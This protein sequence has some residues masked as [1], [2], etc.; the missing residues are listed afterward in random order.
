MQN[1]LDKLY[2]VNF[3]KVFPLQ[4][5][6]EITYPYTIIK[7]S[8]KS[9]KSYLIF[10]YLKQ[11]K[12]EQY[13]YIDLNDM[14]IDKNTIFY[15]L[16]RFLLQNR[17]I[18]I[19]VLDNI[20]S[21][22]N[23][24]FKHLSILKS[25]IISTSYDISYKNFKTVLLQPLDF[26]EFI[27]FDTKHH[28]TTNKF[29][30][31]LKYGNFPEIV[32]FNETKQLH[33][34]QEILQLIT[35]NKIE[36][37]ILKLLIKSSGELKSI[38]QLFNTLKKSYKISKDM[39]YKTSKQFELNFIIFFC[40]KYE[41]PKAT[42]R[43]YC[44]NHALIDAVNINKKFQNIFSNMIFLELNKIYKNI[45]YLDN[46]DFYIEENHSIILSIPFFADHI[47]LS[48]KILPSLEQYDITNIT[49]ITISTEKTVFIDD[50][51]CEVIPFYEWALGL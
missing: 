49:I 22:P 39:F 21:L 44:Y 10:D 25:L 16:D 41:Q 5:K 13:L 2:E 14:R 4:R 27:L 43:I 48:A 45:Y 9:G 28:N 24:F 3:E 32:Q 15:N 23:D 31:F 7:G 6:V 42:K 34:N 20:I 50:I 38:F 30:S 26:E 18:E 1:I 46:I 35:Q 29:N 19:L 36:L 17:D 40:Q 11:Y 8:P 51:E 37:E 12:N 33:R 47:S